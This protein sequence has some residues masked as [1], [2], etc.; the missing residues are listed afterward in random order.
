MLILDLL[1]SSNEVQADNINHYLSPIVDKL[2]EFWVG[3]NIKTAN[4]PNGKTIRM[5]VICCSSD[6]PTMRKLCGHISALAACHRCYKRANNANFSGFDDMD[7][8]FKLRDL[9][10]FR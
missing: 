10:E 9:K 8:W 3:I 5:A 4:N 6:I 1:L 2:L 7:E